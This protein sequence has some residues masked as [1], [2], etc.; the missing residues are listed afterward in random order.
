MPPP[1]PAQGAAT[2][3]ECPADYE[4]IASTALFLTHLR[5]ELPDS[6][7]ALPQEMAGLLS[8]CSRLEN[9][10]MR[11]YDESG[12]MGS[13]A[14]QPSHLMDIDALLAA[15]TQ[16][17]SLQLP[18]CSR[19]PNLSPLASMV[20]LQTLNISGCD[21]VSD[22]AS[23]SALVNLQTLNMSDCNAVSDLAPLGALVNMQSLNMSDCNAVSD[24]APLGALV[25]MQRL[26]IRNSC[27]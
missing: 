2:A 26:E 8:A 24:L 9:L 14:W 22:L 4:T 15:G 7:T 21:A 16:L 25:N 12:P 23:L 17:L 3:I 6:A 13:V 20:N 19:L 27:V 11:A 18:C 5:M 1:Q 10:A